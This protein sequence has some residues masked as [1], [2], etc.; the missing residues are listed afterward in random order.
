[1]DLKGNL[2]TSSHANPGCGRREL[3]TPWSGPEPLKWSGCLSGAGKE[4]E[5]GANF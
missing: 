5:V 3:S 1:M 4:G 2:H